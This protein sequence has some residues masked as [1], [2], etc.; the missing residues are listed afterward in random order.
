MKKYIKAYRNDYNAP[1][2]KEWHETLTDLFFDGAY[3]KIHEYFRDIDG[4][5]TV[6]IIPYIS[7]V[8]DS[9][10]WEVILNYNDNSKPTE[11][12]EVFE[13]FYDAMDFVDSGEMADMYL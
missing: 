8:D 11:K 4:T 7:K 1:Y 6:S 9:L 5:H 13:A 12:I 2:G 3:H 10:Y